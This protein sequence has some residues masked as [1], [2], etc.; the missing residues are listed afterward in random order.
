[1]GYADEREYSFSMERFTGI[2]QGMEGN[3]TPMHAS[4]SAENCDASGGVLKLATGWALDD[5]PAAPGEIRSLMYFHKNNTDGSITTTL[6][7]A[8]HDNIYQYNGTSWASIKGSGPLMLPLTSGRFSHV[9]YQKKDDAAHL[10][11]YVL[12]RAGAGIGIERFS[13]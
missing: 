13:Y 5:I 3:D 7:A 4:R 2:D 10:H 11:S 9:N 12:R 8:T 1:M 6:L